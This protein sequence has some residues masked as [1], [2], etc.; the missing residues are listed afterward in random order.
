MKWRALAGLI[1]FVCAVIAPSAALAATVK[2]R[3]VVV[4]PSK[5]KT[6]TANVKS[7]LP[8][9]I[10]LND[11]VETGGLEI[12]YDQ[13]QGLFFAYKSSVELAPGETKNY[14]IVL[15]DVW[16]V[17]D[18]KLNNYTA[19]TDKLE[20]LLKDTAYAEEAGQIIGKISGNIE[21]IRITQ[22]DANITRQQHIAAYRNNLGTLEVIKDDLA[23][24]EKI[25]VTVGGPPNPELIEESEINL[26]A[27]SSK[28]TW[29]LIFVVMIFVAILSGTFFFTWHR[30]AKITENIFSHE[31]DNSFSDFK[32]PGEGQGPPDVGKKP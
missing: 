14:E 8:K 31:K 28:T 22:S 13:E 26:K 7:Y 17:S 9:E 30:Q 6:Q 15:K 1:F 25:L 12:E 27:P 29:I 2:M 4:N 21:G 16:M 11:V 19:R 5:T 32:A 24:L 18:E 20:E 3:V 23:K 10:T